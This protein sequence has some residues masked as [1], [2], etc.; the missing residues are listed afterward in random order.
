[1]ADS[2]ERCPLCARG[3]PE[4]HENPRASLRATFAESL[5]PVRQLA[6]PWVV[7]LTAVLAGAGLT[8]LLRHQ[9]AG[10]VAGAAVC[11]AVAALVWFGRLSGRSR[12]SS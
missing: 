8:G 11:F 9:D 2:H 5:A 7:L 4:E 10:S 6:L 12:R 3:M 1:M